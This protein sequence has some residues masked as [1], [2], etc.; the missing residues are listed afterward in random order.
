MRRCVGVRLLCVTALLNLLGCDGGKRDPEY[1]QQLKALGIA[2]HSFA[3]QYRLSPV[4]VE[5]LQG[6]RHQFPR[7]YDDVVAGRFIVAWAAELGQ[8]AAENDQYV[9][10]YE[11]NVPQEGG[12]VLLGG[13]TVRHMSP[14]EF[15]KLRRF[16]K[17][18]FGSDAAEKR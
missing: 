11:A 17:E 4:D 1:E 7:V 3:A 15:A 14:E 10:G 8:T 2:Y 13:G 18:A 6:S 9:L 12:L 16:K 5:N